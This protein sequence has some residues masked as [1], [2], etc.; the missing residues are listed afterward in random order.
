MLFAR[1]SPAY[2]AHKNCIS[3]APFPFK[4]KLFIRIP[5][6]EVIHRIFDGLHP[7]ILD[8]SGESG[9]ILRRGKCLVGPY[10]PY[11]GYSRRGSQGIVE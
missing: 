9:M 11:Q 3:T 8:A 4:A 6:T 1:F 2:L 10:G 5:Q 7:D